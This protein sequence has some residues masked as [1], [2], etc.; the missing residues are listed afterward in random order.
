[1]KFE[2][3]IT[4]NGGNVD[5]WRKTPTAGALCLGYGPEKN[6]Y[7]C[8]EAFQGEKFTQ[9]KILLDLGYPGNKPLEFQDWTTVRVK[10]QGTGKN[11]MV[12][13]KMLKCPSKVIG[14]EPDELPERGWSKAALKVLDDPSIGLATCVMGVHRTTFIPTLQPNYSVVNGV[15]LAEF[16]RDKPTPW[17]IS[18]ISARLITHGMECNGFY[19]ALEPIMRAKAEKLGLKIVHMTEFLSEHLVGEASYE[20]WK[21]LSGDNTIHDSYEVWLE[22]EKT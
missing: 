6:I 10:N 22:K 7:R 20:R 3:S 9:E 5:V 4:H 14:V 1:M 21:I 12:G 2:R 11:W 15:E 16:P 17:P 19:G 13:W 18:G 8:L